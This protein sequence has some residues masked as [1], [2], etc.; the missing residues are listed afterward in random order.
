MDYNELLDEA[1]KAMP[2]KTLKKERFEMPVVQSLVQGN[3]TII[4]NFSK[5]MEAISREENHAFKYMTKQLAT[6]ASIDSGRLI[7]KG[8]FTQQQVQRI[9]EAY[10]KEFVICPECGR[11]DTKFIEQHGVKRLKCSA[12]GAI[13]SVREQSVL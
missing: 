9:L 4:S 7:L 5:I 6:A 10:I 8:I 1:Y 11:P 3:K 2:E 12:C 13:A